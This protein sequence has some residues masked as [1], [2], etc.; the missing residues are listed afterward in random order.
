MALALGIGKRMLLIC[1]QMPHVKIKA[2]LG[3]SFFPLLN[4]SRNLS[5]KA[6]HI[7]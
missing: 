4:C 1:A 5:L 2:S 7:E 3:F 6:L